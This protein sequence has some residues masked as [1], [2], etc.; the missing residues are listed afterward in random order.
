GRSIHVYPGTGRG[1][2]ESPITSLDLGFENGVHQLWVGDLTGDQRAEIL[3]WELR[4]RQARVVTYVP[5][6][7]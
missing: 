5:P 6:D 4:S 2:S 1:F 7:R 3:V